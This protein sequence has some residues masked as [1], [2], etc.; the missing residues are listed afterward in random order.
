GEIAFPLV[1]AGVAGHGEETA[2]VLADGGRSGSDPADVAVH[3]GVDEV[4]RRHAVGGG[5]FAEF[6]PV[7]GAHEAEGGEI[8][9]ATGFGTNPLQGVGDVVGAVLMNDGAMEG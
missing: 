6:F 5:A 8:A 2:P 3:V 7:L 9:S 4:F 1:L